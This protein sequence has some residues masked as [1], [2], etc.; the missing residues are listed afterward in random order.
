MNPTG[1]AKVAGIV[2][3]PIEHSAS[4]VLHGFWLD[5]LSIDGAYVPLAARPED[6]ARV[7]EGVRLAGL[8]GLNITAPHKEAAFAVAHDCD[9]AAVAAGAV[10]LLVFGKDGRLTG[11][12]TDAAGLAASLSESFGADFLKARI[13]ILLGAGGAARAAVL[14]LDSLGAQEIRI[15]NRHES[16]ASALAVAL[17]PHVN[18]RV[19][20]LA[21]ATW[22]DAA[23]DAALLVNATRAGMKGV[24]ALD[25]PLDPLPANACVC[26]IVYNPLQTDL[27]KRAAGR[28]H[29]TADG[30]GMLMHQGVPAFEAFFGIKPA[31]TSE[32]R[33]TLEQALGL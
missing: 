8:V 2:G 32:L 7:I 6:F 14:A 1:K 4:P 30:L 10:N 33:V 11:R 22:N 25:L 5:A 31:V 26:D 20:P 19:M 27:L 21:W 16:R 28:G 13:A 17:K 12:N 29:K 23:A 18:A 3:W 15:L 24:A 9:A